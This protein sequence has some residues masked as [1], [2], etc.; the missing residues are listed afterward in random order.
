MT[1]PAAPAR[2]RSPVLLGVG[3]PVLL[4]VAGT[5]GT[6]LAWW[7]AVRFGHIPAY[8]IPAPQAVLAAL[9]RE[10]GDL[11]ANT[12]TTLI[13]T[14]AGFG[15]TV[16]GGVLLG[17]VLSLARW[18]EQ[19][20]SPVLVALNAIPK[21]SFA[22]MLLVWLGFG[23]SPKIVMVILVCF[24]PVVLT[25]ITG[26]TSTPAELVEL[27]RALCGSRWKVFTRI[28]FQAAL[29]QMFIGFKTGMPLAVIGAVVAELFAANS[30]LGYM[31]MTRTGDLPVV[32][33]AIG[34]LAVM[35]ILL[36]YAV[37]LV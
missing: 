10:A 9:G 31:I 6:I 14:L 30:G 28:R 22:P 16:V 35:S 17:G 7:L 21:L 34:I 20:L 12:W 5:A 19:A 27:S 37:V 15:L 36:Y 8:I 3:R 13:E 26:L 1:P 29:P 2:R 11:T 32:F 33:A 18:V 25:T 23:Y 24:F 4:P